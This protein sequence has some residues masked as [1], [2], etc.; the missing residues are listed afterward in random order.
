MYS[1]S[2]S[3]AFGIESI[4]VCWKLELFPRRALVLPSGKNFTGNAV[5][6]LVHVLM[7]S[8]SL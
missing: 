3:Y 5:E 1:C 2:L 4:P 8:L 7:A 6:Y